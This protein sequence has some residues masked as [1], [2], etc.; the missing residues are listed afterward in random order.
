MR[1]F[2]EVSRAIGRTNEEADEGPQKAGRRL[3]LTEQPRREN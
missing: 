2:V 1:W 3:P